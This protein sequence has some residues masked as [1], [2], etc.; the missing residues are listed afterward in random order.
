M[1]QSELATRTNTSRLTISRLERGEPSVG[2]A[3][4]TRVLGV[5]GLEDHLDLIAQ[6]D[7][8]GQ[9]LED[10]ALKRPRRSGREKAER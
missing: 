2:L 4:L 1:S 3:V 5:L 9:R 8:L 7:P 6:D 10:L